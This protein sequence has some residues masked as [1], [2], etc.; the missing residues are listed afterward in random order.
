MWSAGFCI[1]TAYLMA[2]FEDNIWNVTVG[3]AAPEAL[4]SVR[5]VYWFGGRKT[6]DRRGKG[7]MVTRLTVDG[8]EIPSRILPLDAASATAI[9]VEMGPIRYPFV[10][11]LNAVLHSAS[12]DPQGRTM[13]LTLSSFAGHQTAVRIFTP[14][15]ARSVALNGRS[16]PGWEVTSTPLGTLIITVRYAASAGTDSIQVK[17]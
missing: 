9:A 14:R 8:R 1:G 4:Q 3:D 2:G 13:N 15:L 16:W 11:S 6:I 12:L 7:S 5:A 17:F 10:D